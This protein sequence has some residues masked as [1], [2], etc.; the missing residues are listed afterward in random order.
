MAPIK[1]FPQIQKLPSTFGQSLSSCEVCGIFNGGTE[2][3]D[4]EEEEKEEE[5]EAV[6][7][8]TSKGAIVLLSTLCSCGVLFGRWISEL[9]DPSALGFCDSFSFLSF[10]IR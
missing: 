7:I 9:E 1:P 10:L 4:D 6:V 5:D 8:S 2:I 3:D